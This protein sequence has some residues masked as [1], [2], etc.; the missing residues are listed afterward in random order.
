MDFS[1]RGHKTLDIILDGKKHSVA[2]VVHQDFLTLGEY[3]TRKVGPEGVGQGCQVLGWRGGVQ[4]DPLSLDRQDPDVEVAHGNQK[5]RDLDLVTGADGGEAALDGVECHITRI[6]TWVRGAAVDE[7][8]HGYICGAS[9]R[10]VDVY[11]T[12]RGQLIGGHVDDGKSHGC[13]CLVVK[14]W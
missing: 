13:L 14:S 3:L 12:S 11:V 2:V 10:G 7:V 1:T 6:D 4:L 5:V 8:A 9:V